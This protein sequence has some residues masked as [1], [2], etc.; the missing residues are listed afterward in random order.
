MLPKPSYNPALGLLQTHNAVDLADY[1]VIED[2]NDLVVGPLRSTSPTGEVGASH[3]RKQAGSSSCRVSHDSKSTGTR[4]KPLPAAS[5]PPLPK[6]PPIAPWPP[7]AHCSRGSMGI[8]S[9][10]TPA[11]SSA[12]SSRPCSVDLRSHHLRSS[13]RCSLRSSA[14]SLHSLRS[15]S[16][17]ESTASGPT[18]SSVSALGSVDDE[19]AIVERIDSILARIQGDLLGGGGGGGGEGRP[20]GAVPAALVNL[21]PRNPVLRR[22]LNRPD[23]SPPPE[24]PTPKG[25]GPKI[26]LTRSLLL[27]GRRPS[28]TGGG[29]SVSGGSDVATT[30]DSEQSSRPP[31][32]SC[33]QLQILLQPPQLPRGN[34]TAPAADDSHGA[35]AVVLVAVQPRSS[36]GGDK[37]L[38]P[39]S[40]QLHPQLPVTGS[41]NIA[42]PHLQVVDVSSNINQ[43][44]SKEMAVD[45][46][47][48][49]LLQPAP[50]PP[51]PMPSSSR[52]PRQP[53]VAA[54][55]PLADRW[56]HHG[57][58]RSGNGSARTSSSGSSSRTSS[59]S[60]SRGS[61]WS[62]GIFSRQSSAAALAAADGKRAPPEAECSRH[63][64][65]PSLAIK[66][67]IAV[68]QRLQSKS[69]PPVAAHRQHDTPQNPQQQR[70]LKRHS[71]QGQV[72]EGAQAAAGEAVVNGGHEGG[73]AAAAAGGGASGSQRAL[74]GLLK[75]TAS[76]W[77][78]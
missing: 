53:A 50:L 33:Q 2:D 67:G 36:T 74:R 37:L 23:L 8:A 6:V 40:H 12:F 27:F 69:P 10:G 22:L 63:A 57:D 70:H 54:L 18:A 68:L 48:M 4:S 13:S 14:Q 62:R 73:G 34:C 7:L 56:R 55:P 76:S 21:R 1:D 28:G 35:H 31:L 71:Y 43:S 59:S 19:C 9:G 46:A 77:S 38:S 51:P 29:S 15:C 64:A 45:A 3:L 5:L 25:P 16:G 65:S 44:P 17:A 11:T 75:L 24:P 58:M 52:P 32:P 47:P 66:P 72:R 42:A 41:P 39:R 26:K 20:H 30:V 78:Q 60:G 49:P 61:G